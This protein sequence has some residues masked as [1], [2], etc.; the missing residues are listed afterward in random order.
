[1]VPSVTYLH[2]AAATHVH[3]HPQPLRARARL[4]THLG[5]LLA[6]TAPHQNTREWAICYHNDSLNLAPPSSSL[7]MP[8]QRQPPKPAAPWPHYSPGSGG[9]VGH[10]QC[11]AQSRGWWWPRRLG[12]PHAWGRALLPHSLPH[13]VRAETPCEGWRSSGL[14]H[15]QRK[16][17]TRSG[18][19]DL[20]SQRVVPPQGGV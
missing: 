13:Q 11:Q 14:A 18:Q 19:H 10:S 20:S 15:W 17:K 12:L 7:L 8:P 6:N 16:I 9:F 5:A 3:H 4:P 1:M 2:N